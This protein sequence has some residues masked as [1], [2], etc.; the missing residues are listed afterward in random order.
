[1]VLEEAITMLPIKLKIPKI[2]LMEINVSRM[3][4][5]A[6][7]QHR[8]TFYSTEEDTTNIMEQNPP[9]EANSCFLIFYEI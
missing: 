6:V 1:M 9:R 3:H 5:F 7:K 2:Y 8:G 4:S